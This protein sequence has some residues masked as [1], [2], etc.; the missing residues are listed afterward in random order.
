MQ[1]FSILRHQFITKTALM[2][3]LFGGMSCGKDDVVQTQEDASLQ[4]TGEQQEPDTNSET[5][6]DLPDSDDDVDADTSISDADTSIP[7]V[8]TDL[9]DAD[10][11]IPDVDTD[12]PDADTSIPDVDTDLPDADTSISD[13]D[14]DLLDSDISD[15][16]DVSVD[17]I[18]PGEY[19][20]TLRVSDE[21]DAISSYLMDPDMGAWNIFSGETVYFGRRSA[22][23]HVSYHT[24]LRFEEV[25]LPVGVEILEAS[26]V[27]TPHNAVDRSHAVSLNVYA[28]LAGNSTAFDSSNYSSGRPDQRLRTTTFIDGWSVRC[29][30]PCGDIEYDCPQRIADCWDPAVGYEVPKDLNEIIQE[31][32]ELDDWAAGNALTLF[33]I[34]R[35]G[36]SSY[37]L[38]RYNDGRALVG[39]DEANPE[40]SPT[41]TIR[42]LVE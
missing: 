6:T 19:T 17:A 22:S 29:V 37:D 18:S 28:E 41:L 4:D 33:F 5:D 1:I 42:Y 10:T 13:V 27:I 7:D 26:L 39:F 31:V 21:E 3:F 16:S 40:Q 38:G 24:A 23:P 25:N 35:A 32:I 2:I 12:L 30:D 34:N 9:P 8:D 14:T 15:T 11:S 36:D 20:I